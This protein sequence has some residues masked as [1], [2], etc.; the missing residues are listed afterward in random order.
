MT[1]EYPPDFPSDCE[2][3][4]REHERIVALVNE[5]EV[6]ANGNA[7]KSDLYTTYNQIAACLSDHFITEELEMRLAMYQDID[8]HAD[9]HRRLVS[10]LGDAAPLFEDGASGVEHVVLD[11]F[12][13]W[14]LYHVS[15]SDRKFS[16]VLLK[17][18][19]A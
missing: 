1:F 3:L 15:T 10:K 17:S 9:D 5:F 4:N 19:S 6:S 7:D 12:Y 14:F 8:G 2:K 18:P 16:E 13:K 11:F